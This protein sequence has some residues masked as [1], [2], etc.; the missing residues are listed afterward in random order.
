MGERENKSGKGR[1]HVGKVVLVRGKRSKR[2]CRR[3]LPNLQFHSWWGL[4]SHSVLRSGLGRVVC[5][6]VAGHF[7]VG[8]AVLLVKGLTFCLQITPGLALKLPAAL[9]ISPKSNPIARI[10]IPKVST[11]ELDGMQSVSGS[12]TA[13]DQFCD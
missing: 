8:H 5:S 11:S 7:A 2:F 12:V 10:S 4:V 3:L 9:L 13:A 1:L 6:V